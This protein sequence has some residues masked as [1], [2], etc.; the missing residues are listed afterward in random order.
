MLGWGDSKQSVR[1]GKSYGPGF[2]TKDQEITVVPW[3]H[4][5]NTRSLDHVIYPPPPKQRRGDKTEGSNI[6]MS[7]SVALK[8]W[9][10][11]I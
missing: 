9:S 4:L 11:K 3:L 2:T 7:I 6:I 5:L 10:I 8:F 1:G